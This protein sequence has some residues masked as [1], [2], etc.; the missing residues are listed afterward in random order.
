EAFAAAHPQEEPA[1]H[2]SRHGRR[3]LGNDGRVVADGRAG[4]SGTDPQP[5]RSSR[6]STKHRP[7]KWRAALPV[8]PWVVV[9]RNY[10]EGKATVLGRASQIDELLGPS[11]FARQCVANLDLR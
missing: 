9:I 10:R 1:W 11:L 5:F 8:R 6:D 7:D 4:D 3:G 2:E